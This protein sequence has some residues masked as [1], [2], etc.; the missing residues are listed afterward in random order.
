[1]KKQMGYTRPCFWLREKRK[2]K[3]EETEGNKEYLVSG[4]MPIAIR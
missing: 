3:V 4:G 2:E 1:M